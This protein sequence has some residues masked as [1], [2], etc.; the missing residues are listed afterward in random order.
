MLARKQAE[1]QR[2]T[3]LPVVKIQRFSTH[4]GPG[5]RT[6]VFLKGCPL[7]CRWCHNPEML[8]AVPEEASGIVEMSVDEILREVK[9][10]A[11][12]Y[13]NDG[14]LTISGGEPLLHEATLALI[15][16][17]KGQGVH[18]VVQTSGHFVSEYLQGLTVADLVMWDIKDTDD[19]R[20]ERNTG[21]SNKQILENLRAFDNLGGTTLLRCLLVRGETLDAAHI[22]TV[23]A[24]RCEL[25]HC[26]GVAFLACHCYSEG[27][28]RELG[29]PWRS[30]V[31]DVPSHQDM[32]W[33]A[34]IY[35]KIRKGEPYETHR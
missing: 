18:V 28:Y 32:A 35:G 4:D 26:K 5:I 14:G 29:L 31:E 1:K 34:D 15:A 21:V 3:Q 19:A 6:T 17:A 20:H 24:L 9:K 11:A 25:Q 16:A 2:D 23:A 30:G 13:Q 22:E 7:N 33:A 10:D 8:S 12:F 27:K